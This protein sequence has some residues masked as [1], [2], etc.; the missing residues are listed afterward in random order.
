MNPGE[1]FLLGVALVGSA[2]AFANYWTS[3]RKQRQLRRR[4]QLGIENAQRE[5]LQITGEICVVCQRPVEPK[6]D[7][8]DDKTHAWWH[9]DCWREAVR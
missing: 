7:I 9:R 3:T 1:L 2:W 5:Q 4:E 8:F 6:V